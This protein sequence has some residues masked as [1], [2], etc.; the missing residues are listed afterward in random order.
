VRGD[1]K[2]VQEADHQLSQTF[3]IDPD[4]PFAKLPKKHRDLVLFGP[5]AGGQRP[6]KLAKPLRRDDEDDEED[7]D[8]EFELPRAAAPSAR[9]RADPFGADS[10]A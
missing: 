9:A 10:R 1:R 4:A 2:L 6:V 7:G 3:G 8:E 5:P